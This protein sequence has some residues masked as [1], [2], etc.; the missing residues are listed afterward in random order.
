MLAGFHCVPSVV[1][2][3]GLGAI[4]KS[5]G[6][7]QPR[8]DRSG[9]AG[10]TLNCLFKQNPSIAATPLTR[11]SA[12][13]FAAPG[14][15]SSSS[16]SG[17]GSGSC[18]GCS[19]S[20]SLGMATFRISDPYINIWAEDEPLTYQL[21]FL[22]FHMSL[23]LSYKQRVEG[24]PFLVSGGSFGNNWNCSWLGA[25][26]V[27]Q[28]IRYGTTAFTAYYPLGGSFN[29]QNGTGILTNCRAR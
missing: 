27:S 26:D 11:S 2:R 18:L 17:P 10:L 22:D 9:V 1:T 23:D 28:Y 24:Q 8:I 19:G 3:S 16:S 20:R 12:W 5:G 21:P 15:S 29:F 25:I 14:S 6:V 4:I 7:R 13:C